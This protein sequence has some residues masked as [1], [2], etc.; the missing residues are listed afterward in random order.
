MS[1]SP[2]VSKLFSVFPREVGTPTRQ[3]VTSFLAL[4]K[5][6]YRNNGIKDCYSSVYPNT[7]KVDKMFFD[8]DS[9]NGFIRTRPAA[10]R[11]YE[12]LRN[13][14]FSPVALLSGRK[15]FH[16]HA[17]L[18][19][20]QKLK[21][22]D[23]KV[24]LRGASVK[25]LQ[26]ALKKEELNYIDY[27]VLGDLR[28]LARIPNTMRPPENSSWCVILPQ[29]WTAMS[30]AELIRFSRMPN[31]ISLEWDPQIKLSE[32]PV[33]EKV[34]YTTL[35]TEHIK[36]EPESSLTYDPAIDK[37]LTDALQHRPCLKQFITSPNP[38]HAARYSTTLE[39][40]KYF[41][42]AEIHEIYSRLGW[43]DYDS[44]KTSYQIKTAKTSLELGS[45]SRRNCD[46]LKAL[47]LC[48]GCK[49]E[50]KVS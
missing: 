30:D 36:V 32:L 2:M 10:A 5:F 40:L 34:A 1:L 49:L 43:I 16:I 25:I 12:Y 44:G 23:A 37:I 33:A 22:D 17:P 39:L 29:D 38:P 42:P 21:N 15:G 41:E 7:L 9:H 14:S 28:R 24:R 11:L 27:S 45:N 13:N 46:T 18:K 31:F 4:E 6:I 19:I 48:I 8:I 20:E 50:V 47:G 3:T 26:S 35:A